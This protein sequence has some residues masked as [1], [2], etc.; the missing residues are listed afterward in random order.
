MIL[1]VVII[2]NGTTTEKEKIHFLPPFL[3]SKLLVCYQK[4][5]RRSN[6]KMLIDSNVCRLISENA[7]LAH[8]YTHSLGKKQSSK[9]HTHTYTSR[10]AYM[11]EWRK[12]VQWCNDTRTEENCVRDRRREK[13][14]WELYKRQLVLRR[15]NARLCKSLRERE[16]EK[17]RKR[18]EKCLLL[19][20]VVVLITT[21]KI[22]R[23]RTR[24]RRFCLI[25]DTEYVS[26]WSISILPTASVVE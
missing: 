15:K 17:K 13:E 1:I 22:G 10:I 20:V 5:G 8:T 18:S 24:S 6:K 19:V 9:E 21:L 7:W 25:F 23:A 16:R 4:N 12:L 11:R 2:I 3:S 14:R 26:S